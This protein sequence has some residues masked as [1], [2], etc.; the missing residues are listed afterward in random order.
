M[1][2]PTTVE[3]AIRKYFIPKLI[4]NIFHHTY[5]W[6][7]MWRKHTVQTGGS[8]FDQPV[9]YGTTP[10]VGTYTKYGEYRRQPSEKI[11]K[12]VVPWADY[13][14]TIP[15]SK[16]ELRENK[17]KDGKLID[18]AKAYVKSGQKS[19]IDR[20]SVDLFGSGV[21]YEWPAGSGETIDPLTGL[22]AIV[23]QNRTYGGINSDTAGQE[24]WDAQL[25]DCAT[26]PTSTE[27]VTSSDADYLPTIF[28]TMILDCTDGSD[29]PTVIVTTKLVWER[30]A[31]IAQN[32][33]RFEKRS[34]GVGRRNPATKANMGFTAIMFDDVPVL[35]DVDCP[36]GYAYFL[37]EDYLDMRTLA[38][39]SMD[40]QGVEDIPGSDAQVATILLST[41]INCSK[42]SAQ[43]VITSLPTAYA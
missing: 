14:V 24:W 21:T 18:L 29:R 38:G 32:V 5:L 27:I 6:E 4:D 42:C 13:Y 34:I 9:E 37:N 26:T 28:R 20:L 36:A 7:Q 39:A 2:I 16:K 30:L 11:T 3:T 31:F 12:S 17:G 15:F 22:R 8:G 40:Y 23:A 35:W 1:A 25:Y 43:G 33:E 10:N 41:N 19:L